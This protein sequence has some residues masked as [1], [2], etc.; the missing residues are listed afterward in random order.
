MIR[1]IVASLAKFMKSTTRSME[2]WTSKSVLNNSEVLIRLIKNVLVLN[3]RSLTTNLGGNLVVRKTGSREKGNLLSTGNRVHHINGRDTSLNHFLW[4]LSLIRVNRLTL[5]VKEVF[6]EDGWTTINGLT[7]TVELTT[8]HL[9]RDWHAQNITSELNVRLQII[10][11]GSTFENLDD[12]SLTADLENLTFSN[13]TVSKTDVHD[14][15]VFGEFNIVE[16]D[17]GTLDIEHGT[18]IDTRRDIV[19]T[20]CSAGVNLSD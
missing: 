4:V 9:G 10:N 7:G 12:G 3:K 8:Q 20:D 1:S 5:N 11:I 16:N 13:L 17:K 2:P 6:G 19:V 14:L 15:G 18:V